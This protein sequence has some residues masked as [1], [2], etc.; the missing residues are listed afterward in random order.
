[1][2][3][4]KLYSQQRTKFFIRK[5]KNKKKNLNYK[6]KFLHYEDFTFC[7]NFFKNSWNIKKNVLL[8]K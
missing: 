4:Q 2:I 5:Y 1:M 3:Q 7:K 8:E 6:T